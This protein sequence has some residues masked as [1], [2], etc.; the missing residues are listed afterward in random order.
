MEHTV[1][2]ES[3]STS[4]S[5]TGGETQTFSSSFLFI[6]FLLSEIGRRMT[7]RRQPASLPFLSR[8]RKYLL[9]KKR[10]KYL[11]WKEGG[12]EKKRSVSARQTP[13]FSI[14]QFAIDIE[15]IRPAC[16]YGLFD[17][18]RLPSL[19]WPGWSPKPS[20]QYQLQKKAFQCFPRGSRLEEKRI[21][22]MC[23]LSFKEDVLFLSREENGYGFIFYCLSLAR[24]TSHPF[25]RSPSRETSFS[26]PL[27][28]LIPLPER[29]IFYLHP[30]RMEKKEDVSQLY[31][32][33]Y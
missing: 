10:G 23:A 15:T 13:S 19:H 25:S 28:I 24:G 20:H 14:F 3:D 21:P 29:K 12:E 26:L 17:P 11:S 4:Y 9:P 16:F 22:S 32:S 7:L 30:P 1:Q 33:R 2:N 8:R 5:S 18:A 6:F 31:S 27:T